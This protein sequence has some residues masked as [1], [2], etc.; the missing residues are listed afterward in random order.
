MFTPTIWFPFKFQVQG[1]SIF[2]VLGISEFAFLKSQP[3]I[4]SQAIHRCTLNNA[5]QPQWFL[6]PIALESSGELLNIPDAKPRVS[7]TLLS[8]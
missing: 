3:A 8:F 6:T 4:L 1:L 2:S 5:A 7:L